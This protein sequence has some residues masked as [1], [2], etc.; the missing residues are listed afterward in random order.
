MTQCGK[1][2]LDGFHNGIGFETTIFDFNADFRRSKY[3]SAIEMFENKLI[4]LEKDF[5]LLKQGHL[6]GV[7]II[8]ADP[9]PE[10]GHGA[11]YTRK[12]R[13]FMDD[14]DVGH[15]IKHTNLC[16]RGLGM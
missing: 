9:L 3:K 16:P 8:T 5:W 11:E 7:R 4:Q 13:E 1:R 14:P 15:L 10:S 6:E 12:P 2:K